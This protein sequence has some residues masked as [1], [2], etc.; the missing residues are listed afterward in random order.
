MIGNVETLAGAGVRFAEGLTGLA[1]AARDLA[2]ALAETFTE[3]PHAALSLTEGLAA[4]TGILRTGAPLWAGA[5]RS[6]CVGATHAPARGADTRYDGHFVGADGR[7]FPPSTPL[8]EIPPVLPSSGRDNGQTILYVNGISTTKDSQF[9]SLRE[10]ADHTGARVVGIHNATQGA[11]VDIIQSGGDTLDIGRN[12]A[13]DALASTVYEEITAGRTV[14]LMAHSQGALITSRA[15][16]DVRG[17]LMLEDGL[18]RR[19][20]ERVLSRVNVETFGGAAGSYPD[21]PRYV[22][23]VNRFD[24]VSTLFGLGPFANPLVRPGRGAVVHRFAEFDNAHGF[25]ATYLPRRVPFDEA[26][27]GDFD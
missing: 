1:G 19:E 2:P 9:D 17:R 6:A 24:P 14:N 13:V 3:A 23:Y 21:G 25:D 11:L 4:R 15:L 8:S 27:R 26:R 5:P 20:A 18:S 12:P 10:I 22:H 7:T 16:Q